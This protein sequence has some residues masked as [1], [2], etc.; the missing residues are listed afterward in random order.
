MDRVAEPL[1][2]S[3]HFALQPAEA[4]T[5]WLP[6]GGTNSVVKQFLYAGAPNQVAFEVCLLWQYMVDQ[7]FFK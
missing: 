7:P 5:H 2:A 4:Y 3:R 1:R 6:R